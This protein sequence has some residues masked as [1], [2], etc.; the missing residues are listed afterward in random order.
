MIK[1]IWISLMFLA[2][3]LIIPFSYASATTLSLTPEEIAYIEANPVIRV[4]VDPEFVPFEFIE[5]GEYKGIA[6]D[7]IKLIESRTGLSFHVVQDLTWTEAYFEALSGNIDVLPA[8][9]KTAGR[10]VFFNFSTPYIEFKR[11]II[12]KD[13]NTTIR[14]LDDLSGKTVA[15]HENSSHH[16]FLL[17]YPDVNLSL[18]PSVEMALSAVSE[19]SEEVYVGNLS[20]ANFILKNLGISNLR[21]STIQNDVKLE[22]HFAIRKDA[23]ELLSIINK[24]LASVTQEEK[25]AIQNRWVALDTFTD[26]SQIIRLVV[27]IASIGIIVLGVSW[28]WVAKLKVEIT[29]RKKIQIELEKAKLEAEEANRIKSSFM[30]RMSHEIRTPL[31][32]IT[33]LSYLIKQNTQSLTERMYAERISQASNTMLSIIN[34]ILDYSKIE[35]GK[36]AFEMISFNLDDMIQNVVSIVSVK[37]EEK[38]LGFNLSKDTEVPTYFI[39]DAKRIE[40]VLINLLNNAVK[41]TLSGHVSLDVS[42]K[43]KEGEHYYLS[44]CVRDTG[45]G[46]NKDQISALFMPF[47]QADASINRRFGGTGLGLSISKNLVEQ[48]GGTIDVYS[49]ENEGSS[50]VVNLKLQSDVSRENQYK[51][52]I[53]SRILRGIKALILEKNAST[54]H[55]LSSY[56]S[57]YGIDSETTTS[58]DN[59]MHLLISAQDKHKHPFDLLIIDY[60]T[61]EENGLGFYHRILEHTRISIKPKVIM[62][63]PMLRADLF[64]LIETSPV[65]HAI[66]KPI[67]P[68]LLHYSLIDLFAHQT[69]ESTQTESHVDEAIPSYEGTLLVVDDS[70]TNVLIAT[71]LLNK[72]G[73]E[74][75]T[76]RDGNEAVA[77]YLKHKSTLIGILMDLHMPIMNGFEATQEIRKT[78]PSIP[79]IALTADIIAGVKEKCEA[80][81]MQGCLSKPFNPATLA[82]SIHT[83]LSAFPYVPLKLMNTFDPNYGLI[84]MGNDVSLLKTILSSFLEEYALVDKHLEELYL[85]GNYEGIDKLLHKLKSSLGLI[86]PQKLYEL[87]TKMQ[88][89]AKNQ[90]HKSFEEGYQSYVDLLSQIIHEARVYLEGVDE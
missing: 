49:Q 28:Y 55:I 54:M 9:S 85:K 5:N 90:E 34:D 39:G 66:G 56:L 67:I 88:H 43:A 24:A 18:Y 50:F 46:M 76:A 21:F 62:L 33:G 75:L 42:L 6:S 71:S 4:G 19:G 36:I 84:R 87:T 80:H 70:D 20:T 48:M 14:S 45:I 83:I 7:Y 73:Y 2:L 77:M 17:D 89:Y 74:T 12:T 47:T 82:S 53:Q 38:K 64:D 52:V 61:P 59:A 1:R 69:Y 10:E 8:I 13:T 41:F 44:F 30:A 16:S 37:I 57:Q 11:A 25:A 68:S 63:L 58:S 60:E 23:P 31:N 40:Q 72:T 35:A 78:N 86:G 65:S 81:G 51:S 27:I 79:I 26:Y 3:F 32:A 22:L 29:N 15:V